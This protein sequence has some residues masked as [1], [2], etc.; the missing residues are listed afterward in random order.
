ME[1][2]EGRKRESDWSKDFRNEERERG[3][4]WF[5]AVLRNNVPLRTWCPLP[6]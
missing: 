3:K 2:G 4:V 1:R 5:S 6:V